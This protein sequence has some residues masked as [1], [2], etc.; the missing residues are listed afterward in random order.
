MA[1]SAECRSTQGTFGNSIHW[2]SISDYRR[3]GIGR[4]LVAAFEAE[5]RSRGALSAFVATD[6]NTGMTSLTG[7]DLYS[8]LTRHLVEIRDL[9]RGHPFG[10]YL[11]VGYVITGVLPDANGPGRPDIFMAKRLWR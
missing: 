3:Q 2:S 8:D 11:R 4:A 1:G 9:G 5:A 6:D 7:V 10:F